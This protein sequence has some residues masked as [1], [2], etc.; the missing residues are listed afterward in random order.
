MNVTEKEP[1]PVERSNPTE[2][3]TQATQLFG[4]AF[5]EVAQKADAA[6]ALAKAE[7]RK[8]ARRW[9]TAG[10]PASAILALVLGAFLLPLELGTRAEVAAQQQAYQ[11]RQAALA[12][13]RQQIAAINVT[14]ST[15]GKPTV[16]LPTDPLDANSSV[17]LARVLLQLP[18]QVVTPGPRGFQ[19][20]PGPVGP[21]GPMGPP[22]PVGP[23]GPQGVP[24]NSTTI[25]ETPAPMP[26]AF[27]IL[28]H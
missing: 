5:T 10:I 16:A 1:S 24:G 14:L 19:G 12:S 3:V 13:A 25:T 23:I 7:A 2:V 18:K 21:R 11:S 26:P 17:A 15:E 8:V 28:P 9:Y 4:E 22:G 27:P 6:P 20:I